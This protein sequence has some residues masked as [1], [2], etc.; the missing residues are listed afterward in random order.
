MAKNRIIAVAS[1]KGGVGKTFIS[2]NLCFALAQ[3]LGTN[4]RVIGIDLDLGCGNLNT[5]FGVRSPTGTVNDFLM[6]RTGSLATAMTSTALQNLR[7]ISGSYDGL[8]DT[9]LKLGW[10]SRLIENLNQLDA[11]FTILDLAAGTSVNV[12]DFFLAAKERIVIFVPESLSLQN[13]FLFVKS[14][15]V[16]FIDLELG[17]AEHTLPIRNK[18][19]EIIAKEPNLDLGTLIHRIKLCVINMY[20]GGNE[21][22]YVERFHDLLLRRLYLRNFQYLGTVHYGKRVHEAIQSV[23]PFLPT[24]PND[25]VSRDIREVATRLVRPAEMQEPRLP[26]LQE[27]SG[28]LFR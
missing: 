25:V 7:L 19:Y 21:K 11:T 26:N 9:E 14:A 1:G 8:I 24:Y 20:R 16:R 2:A 22:K 3:Q 23:K 6:G 5:C 27:R 17:R 4:D 10:R 12:L 28:F 18:V 15:I 13:A